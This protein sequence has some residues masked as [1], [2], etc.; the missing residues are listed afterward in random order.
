MQP[1]S[2][3]THLQQPACC[4]TV[5]GAETRGDAVEIHS[6]NFQAPNLG[7]HVP[8]LPLAGLTGDSLA[9]QADFAGNSAQMMID[10]VVGECIIHKENGAQNRQ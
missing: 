3:S 6:T 5:F 8:N 7:L 4:P 2:Q 9:G 10:Q 1:A